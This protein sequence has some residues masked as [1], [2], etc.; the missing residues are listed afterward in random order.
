MDNFNNNFDNFNSFSSFNNSFSSLTNINNP[1]HPNSPFNPN[2]LT[3]HKKDTLNYI[4]KSN[5]YY[6]NDDYQPKSK[7]GKIC[8]ALVFVIIILFLIL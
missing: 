4:D 7:I 5:T 2:N 8:N 3:D 1:A 6:Y